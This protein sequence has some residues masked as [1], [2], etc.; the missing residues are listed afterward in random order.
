MTRLVIGAAALVL[1]LGC[2]GACE[3]DEAGDR[4]ATHS[5]EGEI[6]EAGKKHGEPC[7][8]DDEC[9]YGL[10]YK[11]SVVN[12]GTAGICTK[13]CSCGDETTTCEFD[14]PTDSDFTYNC[15]RPSSGD[16]PNGDLIGYC[17]PECKSA[18]DQA[19][20][21][22]WC[23]VHD[24]AYDTCRIVAGTRPVCTVGSGD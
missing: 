6:N 17:L 4:C 22:E 5:Y 14:N 7:Q 12:G 23:Q 18:G 24:P 13:D 11:H 8:T 10:C 1:V 16:E 9:M 3:S 19:S 20:I 2:F 21:T 15:F